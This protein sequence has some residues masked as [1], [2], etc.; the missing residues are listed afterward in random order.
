MTY[1]TTNLGHWY[2]PSLGEVLDAYHAIG[3]F[4]KSSITGS[5]GDYNKDWNWKIY[6]V[7]FVQA[8]GAQSVG[9]WFWTS[10]EYNAEDAVNCGCSKDNGGY[11]RISSY[12]K[13]EAN[14]F[15]RPFIKYN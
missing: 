14:N 8:G 11:I 3:H 13:N 15:V 7:V 5:W 2:L 1:P 9:E 4:D 6:R 12:H 10:E